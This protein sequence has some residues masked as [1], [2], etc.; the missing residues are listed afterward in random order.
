MRACP[1]SISFSAKDVGKASLGLGVA[2]AFDSLD[3]NAGNIHIFQISRWILASHT[4]PAG[5]AEVKPVP[6]P[7][8]P[9]RIASTGWGLPSRPTRR[10]SEPCAMVEY[11][12][13][14]GPP[15]E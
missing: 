13:K 6:R 8:E 12:R 11:L 9:N 5:L 14:I 10:P 7:R 4:W 1:C 3:V 15:R 2:Q